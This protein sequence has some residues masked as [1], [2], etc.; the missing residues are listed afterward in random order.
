MAKPGSV[1][2]ASLF[3]DISLGRTFPQGRNT[4]AFVYG[5]KVRFS[6]DVALFQVDFDHP[7]GAYCGVDVDRY[8]IPFFS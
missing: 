7:E 2:L 3:I 4:I 6:I 1:F 8:F 5:L